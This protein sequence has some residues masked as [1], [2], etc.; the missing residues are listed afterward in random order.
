MEVSRHW[1][2]QGQRYNLVGSVCPHCGKKMIHARAVC[3][4][5]TGEAKTPVATPEL[6][7]EASAIAVLGIEPAKV[8]VVAR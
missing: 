3:P 5:C 1:R 7:A 2:L 4:H 6:H 8:F